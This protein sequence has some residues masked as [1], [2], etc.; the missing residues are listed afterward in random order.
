MLAYARTRRP[1]RTV[2]AEVPPRV[3]YE[4]TELGLSLSDPVLRVAMWAADHQDAIIANR[5]AFDGDLQ[6]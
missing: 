1:R 5:N 3:E 2:Y 4:V 6:D